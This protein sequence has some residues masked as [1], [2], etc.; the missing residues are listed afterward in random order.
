VLIIQPQ[1]ASHG[2]TLTAADTIVW[3][4]PVT[5]VETYLQANARIN[6]PGQKNAM[7]VVHI[8]GSPIEGELYGMLR[9]NIVNHQKI[10]ELYRHEIDDTA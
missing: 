6:R 3:Y 5:S 8:K 1:A 9:N 10:I 2:L 7:T 4:A